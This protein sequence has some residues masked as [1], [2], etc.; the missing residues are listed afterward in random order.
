MFSFTYHSLSFEN[1]EGQGYDGASNMHGKWNSLQALFLIDCQYAYY[2]HCIAHHL[3]LA[4]LAALREVIPVHHFF[5]KLTSVI[6]I[7]G[8]LSKGNDES[9]AIVVAK[10]IVIDEHE[11]RKGANPIGILQRIGDT[12]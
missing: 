3:Q 12:L 7:V 11:T 1:I 9:Q 10:I 4:L 2:T 5:L 8:T 6:N